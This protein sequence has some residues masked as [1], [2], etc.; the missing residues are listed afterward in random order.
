MLGLLLH[1]NNIIATCKGTLLLVN[2]RIAPTTFV[3]SL[4]YKQ[5][6]R[7]DVHIVKYFWRQLQTNI[8]I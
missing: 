7:Q 6:F 1:L 3:N 8:N 2:L 4:F 5:C